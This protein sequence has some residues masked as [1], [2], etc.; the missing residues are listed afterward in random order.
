[1]AAHLA[2]SKKMKNA[3]GIMDLMPL[4]FLAMQT[5]NFAIGF[6]LRSLT[7]LSEIHEFSIKPLLQL[8]R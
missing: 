8:S 2:K 6:H 7:A 5:K 1:M 3:Q 4:S